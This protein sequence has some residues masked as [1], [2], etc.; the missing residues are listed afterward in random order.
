MRLLL[1]ALSLIPL[2]ALAQ[3]PASTV[4]TP[5]LIE[6]PTE[7]EPGRTFV[8]WIKAKGDVPFK[9][10]PEPKQCIKLRDDDGN[11]VLLFLN[12]ES[13]GYTITVDYAVIHP[14][15]AELESAPADRAMLLQW[16]I[17]HSADEVYRDSHV[18][19]VGDG[20]SPGPDPDPPE[21][22][23]TDDLSGIALV[24][25]EAAKKVQGATREES[26]SIADAFRRVAIK[27]ESYEMMTPREMFNELSKELANVAPA[28]LTKWNSWRLAWGKAANEISQDRVSLIGAFN[29]TATGLRAFK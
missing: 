17:S 2:P 26:L 14:T 28:T 4:M 16:I 24:A 1:L 18:V 23:P 9:V 6:G 7:V 15:P 3:V 27:A 11:R 13:P 20:P 8:V 25:Y 22:D 19:T 5:D 10:S 29:Q 12:A 21:P